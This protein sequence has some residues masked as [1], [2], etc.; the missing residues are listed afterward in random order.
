M[1]KFLYFIVCYKS[2][3]NSIALRRNKNIAKVMTLKDFG[4]NHQTVF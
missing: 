3:R 1:M 4:Q 2:P